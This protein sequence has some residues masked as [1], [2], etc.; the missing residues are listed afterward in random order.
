MGSNEKQEENSNLI[1]EGGS[2]D[3]D[4][5]EDDKH[6]FPYYDFTIS[7]FKRFNNSFVWILMLENF[8]FGLF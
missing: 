6:C 2:N 3:L 7:V 8:N 5:P 4:K 1:L